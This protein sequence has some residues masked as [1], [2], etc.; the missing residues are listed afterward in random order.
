MPPEIT[1][2]LGAFS[3]G[4]TLTLRVTFRP[5]TLSVTLAH[6]T[7]L[8][9]KKRASYANARLSSFDGTD[10]PRAVLRLLAT[11]YPLLATSPGGAR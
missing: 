11:H 7:I 6:D 3:F 8:L 9:K 5:V 1:L 4:V 2:H 10:K